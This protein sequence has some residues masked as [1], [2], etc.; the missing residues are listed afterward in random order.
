MDKQAVRIEEKVHSYIRSNHMLDDCRHIVVGVSGGADSVCLLLMLCDYV[1]KHKMDICIHAVHVNHMIRQEAADDE[2]F[3][4]K[5]CESVGVD[6]YAAHIDCIG[7]AREKGLTVEEAGRLERYRIFDEIAKKYKDDGGVM[8]A[9][10]HHMNDQAETVLMNMARGTSLKGV[11]GIVPVRDNICRPLLCITRGQ[12]ESV[13]SAKDQPYVT[14]VTN[15]DND[16]TRNAIRNVILPYM[17]EHINPKAVENISSMAVNIREAE[18]YMDRQADRLYS[19]CVS[20]KDDTIRMSVSVLK[21][22]DM[23]LVKRVIYRCLVELAGRAKDIYSVNV[24]D[25]AALMDM[26][27][28]RTIHSVYGIYAIREYDDIVLGKRQ[29]KSCI[30]GKDGSNADNVGS[31]KELYDKNVCE[32]D[33]E[34]DISALSSSITVNIGKNIYIPGEGGKYAESITFLLVD[35]KTLSTDEKNTPDNAKICVNKSNN[36]SKY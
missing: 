25:I 10:A 11:R 9:V 27:T 19:E 18:E 26:Q 32:Y 2:N 3:T 4:R 31:G 12:I 33:V 8:I 24:S 34:V 7:I 13:L 30:Q 14:D 29:D 17:C 28:G 5:L 22:A 36:G 35:K 15:F 16:Y 6:C 23:V 1:K 21:S 20:E